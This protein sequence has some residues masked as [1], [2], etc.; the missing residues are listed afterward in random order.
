[1]VLYLVHAELLHYPILYISGYINRN[2]NEYYRLLRGVT[3]EGNWC[4]FIEY[5]LKGFYLQ[6]KETKDQLFKV[7]E[8]FYQYKEEIK[9]ELPGL[10]TGDLVEAMFSFPIHYTGK[11]GSIVEHSLHHCNALLE[12]TARENFFGASAVWKISALHQ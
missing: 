3:A 2:R 5:M 12:A 1:M 4:A 7:R 8:L 11:I 6:A 10:Y 9:K